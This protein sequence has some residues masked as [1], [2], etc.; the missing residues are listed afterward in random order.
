MSEISVKDRD[1]VVPGEV[2]AEGMDYLPGDNT[3]RENER[4]YSKVLGLVSVSGR[5]LKITPLSGPYVPKIGDK[6][7][8]KVIDITMSGWRVDTNTA[9]SAMMNVRDASSRF[10]KKE[11]DL[12][13]INAIGD[14]L[15]VKVTNVTSQRLIDVSM[16]E[17]GLHKIKGGRTIEINSQKVPRVIGKQGSMITLIKTKTGC[18]I[19]IGQNGLVWIKGT[20]E[21]ELKAVEAIK[22]VEQRSHT[23]GLTDQIE[24]FLG[25]Q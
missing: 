3:Y 13:K 18:D 23:E 15:V 8:A 4:I 22:L 10:I 1:I 11:E 12:S 21:G 9:Y 2:L 6:I 17:P 20:P 7:I 14:Y 19:T 5:V 24:K 25:G 16:R